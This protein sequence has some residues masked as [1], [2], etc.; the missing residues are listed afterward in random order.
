MAFWNSVYNLIL[1]VYVGEPSPPAER[2]LLI[3]RSGDN[4]LKRD[5]SS[6]ILLA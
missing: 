3:L 5:G 4:L 6:L 2:S 1:K